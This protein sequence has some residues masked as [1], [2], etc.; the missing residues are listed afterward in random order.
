MAYN[1]NTGEITL[2]G[3]TYT[4]NTRGTRRFNR[5]ITD[6]ADS[7]AALNTGETR[8]TLIAATRSIYR[9][10]DDRTAF[11]VGRSLVRA[12]REE[13]NAVRALRAEAS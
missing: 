7:G 2:N 3:R 12:L 9:I 6:I 1:H 8:H 5:T 4:P 11:T 10:T 13:A